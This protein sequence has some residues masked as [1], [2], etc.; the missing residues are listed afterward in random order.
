MNDRLRQLQTNPM[1]ALEK[2][3][4]AL[5]ARGRR[6]LDFASGAPREPTSAGIREAFLA[7]TPAVSPY[8]DVRGQRAM[9]E[10]AADYLQE[11]F[12]VVV[13]ADTGILPTLGSRE[14]IFHLPLV[15]VQ[16]PSEKDLVLYGEPGNPACELGALFAEAWTWPVPLDARNR[17]LMDPDNIPE[18][19]LR[20]AAI[21]FLGYPHDPSGQ[22]LP[23]TSFAAWVRARDT[24]GFTLVSDETY[25]DLWF[26]EPRPQSVLEF[27]RRGCLA[28]HS[29]SK[30]SGMSGYRSGFVAG[31]PELVTHYRRFRAGM[32][33]VPQDM[34]QAAAAVAWR[35]AQ[36]VEERR[37]AFAAQRQVLLRHFA[38]LGLSVYPGT[39]TLSLWVEVPAA[40][41]DLAY[42]ERCL[43][44]GIL[45]APG[46]FLGPGQDRFVRVALGP[47]LEECA[48]AVRDW[49]R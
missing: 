3:R 6:V 24:Y 18:S 10:A 14:A 15:L 45:V 26:A 33:M 40:S 5:L 25:A 12:G 20:R 34:V 9:R 19:V 11:R 32:G 36:H 42:A 38:E 43:E 39:A 22:C 21:V 28:V 35:D 17:Y 46:S 44:R 1:Q 41:T 2:R 30:R 13:D 8:P 23:A 7:A 31:D 27:G 16:I 48:Q 29:L 4:D 49:P 47:G 37:L